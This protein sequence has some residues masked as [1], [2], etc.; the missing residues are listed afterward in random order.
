MYN[1]VSLFFSVQIDNFCEFSREN[2]SEV[3]YSCANDFP[4]NANRDVQFNATCNRE[5][6]QSL[7]QAMRYITSLML[8][9]IPDTRRPACVAKS[10]RQC[11]RASSGQVDVLNAF[12]ETLVQRIFNISML[13]AQVYIATEYCNFK[14][15]ENVRFPLD[16]FDHIMYSIINVL[17]CAVITIHKSTY[18]DLS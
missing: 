10:V 2:C 14:S 13:D 3:K 15:F 9:S 1:S 16:S 7:Q 11:I 12:K 4:Q 17:I 18:T 6:V 8:S 5:L